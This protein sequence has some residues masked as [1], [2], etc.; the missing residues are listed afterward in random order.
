MN[1]VLSGFLATPGVG[2][3]IY[4]REGV[5]AGQRT[6]ARTRSRARAAGTNPRTFNLSWVGND[7]TFSTPG[8]D[9]AA[10]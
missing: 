4:D 5:T 1:T 9:H 8:S 10:R 3:G 2:T 6:P 7:G